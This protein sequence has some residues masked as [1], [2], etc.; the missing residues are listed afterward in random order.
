MASLITSVQ[1]FSVQA[2]FHIRAR[3]KPLCNFVLGKL[4]NPS[5]SFKRM[6]MTTPLFVDNDTA[7]ENPASDT[8]EAKSM[9]PLVL[10]DKKMPPEIRYRVREYKKKYIWKNELLIFLNG[11]QKLDRIINLFFFGY[12]KLNRNSLNCAKLWV[13][14]MRIR[15]MMTNCGKSC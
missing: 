4:S 15:T 8:P 2:L 1:N 10:S 11:M 9:R 3:H 6:A 5:Y 14:V 13:G 12:Q 7:L